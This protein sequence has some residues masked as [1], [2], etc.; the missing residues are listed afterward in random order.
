MQL[1]DALGGQGPVLV[2]IK[3][4]AGQRQQPGR[5][6][7]AGVEPHTARPG[8]V[9]P[10]LAV[11]RCMA[12]GQRRLAT[13]APGQ[14][15]ERE[16]D[17]LAGAQVVGGV[18]QASAAVVTCC[19]APDDHAV[20]RAAGRVVDPEFREHWRD[21]QVVEPEVLLAAELLA[22]RSL[23]VGHG[24]LGGAAGA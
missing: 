18:V 20:A 22:Q 1:A 4:R 5:A 16:F 19:A 11:F 7:A 21:A 12:G 2:G 8:V 13:A 15:G 10:N 6:S 9:E 23:P 17:V 3:E 14:A 24:Q